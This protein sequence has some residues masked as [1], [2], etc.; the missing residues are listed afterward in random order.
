MVTPFEKLVVLIDGQNLHFT[1]RRLG[2]DVDF[3]RLL[4]EFEARGS[5]VRAFYYTTIIENTEF[6]ALQPLIDWLEYNRFTVRAKRTK[7]FDDGDGRRRTKRSI[8][9]DLAIDALEIARQV[10]H[11][12]LVSGDGDFRTLVEAVQRLGVHVSVASTLRSKPPMISDEL[13]RQADT[14]IELDELKDAIGR[15]IRPARTTR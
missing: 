3:N 4:A 10:D 9:V 8:A 5:L 12:V 14:F 1:A 6:S 7:E 11:M 13:R 15:P 2:F